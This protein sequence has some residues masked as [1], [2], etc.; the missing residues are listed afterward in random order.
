MSK[1]NRVITP[2]DIMPMSQYGKIRVEHRRKLVEVKRLR[3]LHVGPHVT[4]YFE[5]YETMWAQVQATS[6]AC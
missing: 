2:A 1:E 6:R 3:R 4:L 5:S